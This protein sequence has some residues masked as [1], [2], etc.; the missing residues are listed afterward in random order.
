MKIITISIEVVMSSILNK[1]ESQENFFT[2]ADTTRFFCNT[3]IFTSSKFPEVW[4]NRI[5]KQ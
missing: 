5:Q 3:E 1:E 2:L 4:N